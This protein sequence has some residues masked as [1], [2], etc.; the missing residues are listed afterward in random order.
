[1]H[2]PKGSLLRDLRIK[3]GYGLKEFA[4]EIGLRPSQLSAIENGRLNT[5]S[6][7]KSAVIPWFCLK[8]G[9]PRLSVR[10]IKKLLEKVQA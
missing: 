4:H 5:K 7:P 2:S 9:A 1:M 3:A 10:R 8:A 6:R